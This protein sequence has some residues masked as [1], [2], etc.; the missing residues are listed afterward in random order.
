M[1]R[2]GPFRRE[3]EAMAIDASIPGPP[4]FADDYVE[5]D[6][7]VETLEAFRSRHLGKL[8]DPG[9]DPWHG[10]TVLHVDGSRHKDRRRSMS[11]LVKRDAHQWF[12]ER[13]LFPCVGRGLRDILDNPGPGGVS[14]SD[15]P[16]FAKQMFTELA[17]ALSGI[18]VGGDQ[19]RARELVGLVDRIVAALSIRWQLG[20]RRA[21]LE[22]AWQAKAMFRERFFEPAM[23]WHRTL[24]ARHQ[25]G[26]IQ[27]DDLP[28]D[29]M[30]LIVQGANDDWSDDDLALREVVLF[31][32]ASLE[33]GSVILVHAADECFRW[34]ARHPGDRALSTSPAFLLGV[35]N[36][37][38]RLH[39]VGPAFYRTV[40]EDVTLSTGRTLKKGQVVSLRTGIASRDRS[41]FGADADA[42]DPRR[43][44]PA[45]VYDFGLAFGAGTHMC[46][47]LP[48]IVGNEGID[49]SHVWLLRALF[50]AGMTPDPEHPPVKPDDIERDLFESYPVV[51]P[52]GA[53]QVRGRREP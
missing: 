49:G 13:V 51:F 9:T 45:G 27:P 52:R 43:T 6:G 53:D 4:S 21:I 2:A 41:V 10:E 14:R 20:D 19:A 44:V 11:H 48:L 47:G 40:L 7:W 25:A 46:L 42:F 18:D 33:T 50:Q 12:R 22:R 8:T 26:E 30:M 39:P 24:L 31:V 16:V 5:L 29:L 32:T 35:L 38:L 3:E 15:L 37:T 28:R 17:A 36:E 1:A 34:F 23:A